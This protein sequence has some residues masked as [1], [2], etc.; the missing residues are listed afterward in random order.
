MKAAITII[1]RLYSLM[2]L[3]FLFF[4]ASQLKCRTGWIDHRFLTGSLTV[5]PYFFYPHSHNQFHLNS[6]TPAKLFSACSGYLLYTHIY[7]CIHIYI[8]IYVQSEEVSSLLADNF[9]TQ[10]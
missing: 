10:V 7:V 4:L 3:G 8:Y 5:W 1:H 6:L 9:N 2:A